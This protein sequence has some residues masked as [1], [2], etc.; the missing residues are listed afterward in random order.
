[1]PCAEESIDTR[2]LPPEMFVEAARP[3]S[4]YSDSINPIEQPRSTYT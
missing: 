1:M 3:D 4:V 2:R